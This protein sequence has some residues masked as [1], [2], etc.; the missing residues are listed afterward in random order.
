MSMMTLLT[1][2]EAYL[3]TEKCVSRHTFFAYKRDILQCFQLLSL[4]SDAEILTVD[5]EQ[6]RSYLGMLKDLNISARSTAR[7]LSSLKLFFTYVGQ[8]HPM[9]HPIQDIQLPKIEQKLPH[10][11]VES[12]MARL[13]EVADGQTSSVGV[14]NKVMLYLMYVT[15][16]RVSELVK[17]HIDDLLFES[18]FVLVRG[19]GGKQRHIPLPE[20]M[21][22]MLKT[23]LETVHPNTTCLHKHQEASPYLF[24]ITY[25][26]TFKPL[27]RQ[28]FWIILKDLWAKTGIERPLSPHIVRHSLATHLLKNGADLRSLQLILGHENLST[29]QM[30][31]HVETSHLR[32]VYNKKHPRSE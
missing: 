4:T 18:G 32:E 24:S 8:L 30:Y 26:G 13:L 17:L 27:T 2:F 12:E 14:R 22:H 20:S 19:K 10:V 1:K 9:E 7:K 21:I 15:G 25:G 11:V 5:K 28:A 23:Y 16:M 6:I 31:T 29:V 3:L